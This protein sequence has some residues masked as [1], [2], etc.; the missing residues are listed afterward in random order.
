MQERARAPP[1]W[2]VC[3]ELIPILRREIDA[4]GASPGFQ[5]HVRYSVFKE[6]EKISPLPREKGGRGI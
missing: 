3:K 4:E 1:T 6:R 2:I 5:S